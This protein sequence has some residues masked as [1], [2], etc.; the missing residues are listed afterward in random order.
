MTDNTNATQAADT[1]ADDHETTVLA[2]RPPDAGAA[3]AW[4]ETEPMHAGD[5]RSW[6]HTIALAACGVGVVLM[7]AATVFGLG[8][9]GGSHHAPPAPAPKP[10]PTSSPAPAPPP[11]IDQQFV[12]RL[13]AED[14]HYTPAEIPA[15]VHNAHAICEV[16]RDGGPGSRPTIVVG[17]RQG[18]HDLTEIDA[19][20]FLAAAVDYYCPDE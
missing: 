1:T 14:I 19:Y 18:N 15:I 3:L 4:S 6:R 12:D 5:H 7:A 8:R 2:D 16:M 11:S 13:A 10:A 9:V 17:I 20:R